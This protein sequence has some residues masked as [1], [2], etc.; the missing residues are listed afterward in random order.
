MRFIESSTE[1]L[2][3][4]SDFHLGLLL[5]A[6]GMLANPRAWR[7]NPKKGKRPRVKW[8][9]MLLRHG[10][11]YRIKEGYVEIMRGVRLKIIGRS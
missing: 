9:S 2:E 8:L 11:G 1:I 5:T 6:K 7:N 10:S 4:G 3:S